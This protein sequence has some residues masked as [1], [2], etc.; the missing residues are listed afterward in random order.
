MMVA[1]VLFLWLNQVM[2][3]YLSVI[4]AA[5]AVCGC[6]TLPVDAGFADVQTNL[7][8]RLDEMVQWRRGGAEDAEMDR[9]MAQLLAQPLTAE[10]A[11]Q[12]ALL[13]HRGLQAEYEEL[14]VAQADLVQAGLLRNPSFGW[15]RLE[16]GGI[17]KTTWGM[18]LD[19]LGLLLAA[20]MKRI[21][22]IRFEHAKLRVTQAVLRHAA[23]TRKAWAEAL[24]A[25][26]AAEFLRQ[27]GELAEA[28]AELGERQRKA[29]NLNQRD[30]L[31]QQ[32]FAAETRLE[33]L[34]A[35]GSA[36]SARERLN[37]LMGVQGD[38][39]DWK[40][41]SRLPDIPA[42]LPDIPN[43][44]AHGIAQRLDVRMAQKE[45]EALAA[46]LSM[47]RDSRFINVFDLGVETEKN[48][49]EKRITGPTLKLELP[50]F[51][52]GQTRVSRQQA[53]YRQSEQRLYE[54]TV[55][56]RSEI[57]EAWQRVLTT[58]AAARHAREVLLPL[59]RKIVEQGTLH[60][61]GMLIGVYELLVDAREQVN[62]VQK[63]IDTSRDFW[64][65]LADLHMAVGGKLPASATLSQSAPS[66]QA[67]PIAPDHAVHRHQE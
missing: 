51:D 32:A 52:Q 48:T 66:G 10:A 50:I 11:V 15:S 38:F 29:G 18:E 9:R 37:R 8:Q 61:N 3:V 4:M 33:S 63:E 53:L 59:R 41:P 28:E 17:T 47:T 22:G 46:A 45:A 5:L 55:N 23:D 65:A 43:L 31:R 57:R 40:L 2:K 64:V 19:F 12:V 25:E 49:G 1:A 54:T 13:N 14:G 67:I 44:E 21:E 42:S 39:T 6:A 26:Q 27:A 60:Y 30:A 56:A 62:A 35:A 36:F 34:R 16:G 58:H 24:A 20:P 7:A